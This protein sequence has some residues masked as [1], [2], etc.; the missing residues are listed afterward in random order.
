MPISKGEDMN[1]AKIVD[2]SHQEKTFTEIAD[3]PVSVL[4]GLSA[5]DA[6]LLK[7]ALNIETVRDLANAKFV[8]LA[9]AI[10]SLAETEIGPK[11]EAKEALLDE[12]VEMTFPSSD[13]IAV[14]S[15]ITR[16]EKAPELPP[17]K[18]EHQNIQSIEESVKKK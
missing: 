10:V 2:K 15:S 3:A 9:S 11:K 5:A 1:L 7:Q 17:A 8:K 16:I 14:A 12:A 4:H 18:E 13:P 6:K